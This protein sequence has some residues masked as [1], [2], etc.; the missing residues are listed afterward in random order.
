MDL[1]VQRGCEQDKKYMERY[2]EWI[3]LKK[4]EK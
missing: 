2:Y 4:K 3:N 1:R